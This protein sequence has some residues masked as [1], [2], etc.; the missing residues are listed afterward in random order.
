VRE[1]DP[2][3]HD[4]IFA[5]VSH[6]PHVLAFALVDLLA[7]RPDA[8]EVFRCAA[9]G[10]RDFT[11]IAAGSPEM[12]RDI[13]LANRDALLAEIDA[14]R[15][16]LDAVAAMVA[17]ADGDALQ[18]VFARVRGATRMG[19]D[20][21]RRPPF[22]RTG[23]VNAEP[24]AQERPTFRG[25]NPDLAPV[26]APREPWRCRDR[27]AFPI[28][29]CSPRL[30][31]EIRWCGFDADDVD[32]MLDALRCSV[33]A[34]SRSRVARFPVH[35]QGA[36][37]GQSGAPFPGQRRHR[38]TARGGARVRRW[39]LRVVRVPRMHER[40]IGD[41]VDALALSAPISVTSTTQGIRATIA[42]RRA[43]RATTSDRVTVRGNISSQFTS[44]LLMALPLLTGADAR[45]MTVD[46][47]G[48][49]ISKPYVAITTTSC[50]A[51]A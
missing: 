44:A 38:S 2:A 47:A 27:R 25:R 19:R 28:A 36:C 24:A 15:G 23:R 41:L 1:L 40:P 43:D 4:R 16:Q 42:P 3:T 10:F 18:R 33:F 51:S 32:R 6:L 48:D 31:R 12:W 22:P 45:A 26:T 5:A 46:I 21:R 37:P 11:R 29:R 50:G 17:A 14:Y 39:N 9:S 13:S 35:G 30:R 34:S 20:A 8:D 7:A 49:L